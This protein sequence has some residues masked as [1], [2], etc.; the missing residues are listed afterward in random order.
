MDNETQGICETV[1]R[2]QVVFHVQHI[3]D[4]KV[5]DEFDVDAT[6]QVEVPNGCDE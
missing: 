1:P 6:T 2:P 5:I 3:R 4:G